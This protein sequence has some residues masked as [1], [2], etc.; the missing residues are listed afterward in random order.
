MGRIFGALALVLMAAGSA[1]AQGVNAFTDADTGAIPYSA[2]E[3]TARMECKSLIGRFTRDEVAILSAEVIPAAN[4][5]PEHCRIDGVI[6]PQIEFQVNLPKEWNRR[7]YMFGN[8]GLAGERPEDMPRPLLRAN[9][10]KHGFAVASTNTGHDGKREFISFAKNRQQMIDYAYRAVHMTVVM[11]KRIAATYY[12]RAPAFSYWDGCSTGGRQGLMEAQRFPED[13]DGIADGAPVLNLVDT[14]I[15]GLWLGKA[16]EEGNFT[17]AKIHTVADALYKKCDKNDGTDDG[18]IDDPRKCDFDPARDV[19]QCSAGADGDDCLTANQTDALHKIYGGIVS[20]G[21][22]YFF[23]YT[24]GP[25][26]EGTPSLGAGP[27]LSGWA[28][29]MIPLPNSPF[30]PKPIQVLFAIPE[31]VSDDADPKLTYQN[32]DFDKGP[33]N[34][35][36]IRRLVNATDP[37]LTRFRAR[38]GHIIQYHGWADPALQPLMSIDYY[39]KAMAASGAN[40]GDFYRLFMVPGMFHCRGGVGTDKFDVMTRLIDWVEAHKAP[41]AVMAS[42]IEDGKVTRTRPL[43][44]YP[45]AAIYNGSGNAADAASYSCGAEK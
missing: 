16:L 32:Y 24:K 42:R 37:D 10:L 23:G 17:F 1:E 33:A 38:G 4:G 36:A 31:F 41:D 2:T 22:P 30:G 8:G 29:W 34:T 7:F 6:S 39:E 28:A 15:L 25:E 11:A 5:V 35:V 21:K 20:N 13:F 18:V 3:V 45:T 9:A 40:G 44:P 14:Q 26:I 43:C 12:D 27:K 19:K